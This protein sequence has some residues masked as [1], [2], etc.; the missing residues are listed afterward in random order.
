MALPSS[1]Q[2]SM[3]DIR[4]ELGVPTQT[5]FGLDE[6]RDGDYGAINPCS[7]YKP[8]STGQISLSDWYGYNHTQACAATLSWSYTESSANGMMSI[9]LNSVLYIQSTTTGN[10]TFSVN[11]D[12]TIY[13]V[14]DILS[15]C[16][17]G[18][19]YG[20]IY[21][22]SNKY[23]LEDVGCEQNDTVTFTSGTYTVVAGDL[24]NTITLDGYASCN[25]GCL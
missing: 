3:D 25:S 1:G 22:V 14:M 24:G 17:G 4:V 2:I 13:V 9:Y 18:T 16:G 23:Q 11:E 7:T 19:S 15:A 20:N 10:G 8:P 6:A 12:D 5:P 21:T